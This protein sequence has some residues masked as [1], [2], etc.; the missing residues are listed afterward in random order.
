MNHS[1]INGMNILKTLAITATLVISCT[2]LFAQGKDDTVTT[3]KNWCIKDAFPVSETQSLA[4]YEHKKDESG[5]VMVNNMGAIKWEL[6][7]DGCVMAISKYKDYHLIFYTGKGHWD[8]IYGSTKTIKQ[9][10][11]AT[12]DIKSQKIIEDKVIYKGSQYVVPDFQNDPAGNFSQLLLRK[13]S[14]YGWKETAGYILITL[15]PDGSTLNKE[16]PSIAV[17]G[18]FIGSSI[19]KDGSFFISSMQNWSSIVVEKFS[20]EGTLIS[21]LESPLSDI[22]KDPEYYPF[23]KTD[24][25]T[26]NAVAIAVRLVNTDKYNAFSYFG[27]NFDNNQVAAVNEAPLA[28]KTS[29]YTFENYKDLIPVDILFT[30]DKIVVIRTPF[31]VEIMKLNA[32]KET[33]V[34][35]NS[36]NAVVSVYNKQM[37]LQREIITSKAARSYSFIDLFINCQIH[38]EKLFI[39]SSENSG[40]GKFDSFCYTVNL[41]EGSSE[42]KK[43][44][45]RK[46]SMKTCLA[47]PSTIWFKNECVITHLHMGV[48]SFRGTYSSV[49]ERVGFDAL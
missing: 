33:R 18:S 9:I 40:L 16:I 1:K 29:S 17:G 25:C 20:H 13:T 35:Y 27:F 26:H 19:G 31:N 8:K 12:V 48:E 43:I 39:L 38:K 4:I 41:N 22:R 3:E 47:T 34:I 45:S 23:M 49:L 15:N 5:I 11:A 32:G 36:G 30:A 46:P 42:R 24:T 7:F 37:K 6:P 28:K 21:K 44:G 2:Q 14:R 10:N